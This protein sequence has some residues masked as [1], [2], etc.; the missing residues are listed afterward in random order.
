MAYNYLAILDRRKSNTRLT[1]KIFPQLSQFFFLQNGDNVND[2][3]H[4][5]AAP[6]TKPLCKSVRSV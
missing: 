4:A 1:E 2:N 5:N 3:I 6:I